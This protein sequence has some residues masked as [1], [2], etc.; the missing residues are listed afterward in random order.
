[1]A[2]LNWFRHL[3][4]LGSHVPPAALV[5]TL[6]L[7]SGLPNPVWVLPEASWRQLADFLQGPEITGLEG[8]APF[9]LGCV[10]IINYG[11]VPGVPDR[12]VV[13][14][15]I[16]LVQSRGREIHRQDTRGLY[17]WLLHSATDAGL[18]PQV[19]SITP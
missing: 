9:D 18:G 15:G 8:D 4:G 6:N 11:Q 3:L 17:N 12:L 5:A 14:R 7:Y 13:G 19:A 10:I 2:F 16:I 1:M